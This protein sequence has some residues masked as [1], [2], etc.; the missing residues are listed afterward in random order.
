VV[1]RSVNT[2]TEEKGHKEKMD[3]KT[4]HRNNK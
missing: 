3:D 2:L 4:L 1:R